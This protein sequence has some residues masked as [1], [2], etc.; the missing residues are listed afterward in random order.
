MCALIIFGPDETS[1]EVDISRVIP[2]R[3]QYGFLTMLGQIL[4]VLGPLVEDHLHI[5][6]TILLR[7]AKSHHSILNNRLMVCVV[8]IRKGHQI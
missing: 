2:L 4:S 7:L 1:S 6:L 8:Y 3:K 5:F